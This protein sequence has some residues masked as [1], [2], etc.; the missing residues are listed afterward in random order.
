[1]AANG[2]QANHSLSEDMEDRMNLFISSSANYDP[3]SG[4]F[5][6][7]LAIDLVSARFVHEDSIDRFRTPKV[8][9]AQT[10][11]SEQRTGMLIQ[12]LYKWSVLQVEDPDGSFA[13][14]SS[15][16]REFIAC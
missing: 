1:M 15:L 8:G 12:C 13:H 11:A 16:L 2:L 14:S 7:D 6:G 4:I 3:L 10:L 9:Q 5:N